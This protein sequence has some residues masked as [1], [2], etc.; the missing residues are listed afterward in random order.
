M[1]SRYHELKFKKCKY[2]EKEALR[3]ILSTGRNKGHYRTCG[4]DKCLSVN[5]TDPKVTAK[6]VHLGENNP[7]WVGD[8]RKLKRPMTSYEGNLWRTAV[9]ERDNYTCQICGEHGGKLN[10]DHI[11]PYSLYSELKW[12]LDNGRTLCISCHKQTPTYGWRMAS[13]IKKGVQNSIQI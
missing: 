5:Y 7:R 2:C 1:P 9:Y 3:N 10:A 11:K 4:S 12:E 8:R 6:K 13:Y